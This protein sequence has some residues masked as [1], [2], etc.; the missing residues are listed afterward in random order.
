[1]TYSMFTSDSHHARGGAQAWRLRDREQEI[2][3]QVSK[4]WSQ[5]QRDLLVRERHHAVETVEWG[6]VSADDAPRLHGLAGSRYAEDEEE[7]KA[8]VTD[9]V[10]K[11]RF[12][13]Y[14]RAKAEREGA[15]RHGDS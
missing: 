7:F 13:R 9:P 3:F 8:L 5:R 10:S 4:E 6:L 2:E 14:L 11:E 1:M 15:G 12:A